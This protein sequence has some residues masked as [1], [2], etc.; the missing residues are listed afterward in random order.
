[1]IDE[2]GDVPRDEYRT[3]C[4]NIS[5]TPMPCFHIGLKGRYLHSSRIASSNLAMQFATSGCMV[6]MARLSQMCA[7]CNQ[8]DRFPFIMFSFG[9]HYRYILLDDLWQYLHQRTNDQ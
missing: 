8:K 7:E 3:R 5:D 2:I 1:M 9:K 6:M 4:G